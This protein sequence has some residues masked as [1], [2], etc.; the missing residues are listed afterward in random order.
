MNNNIINLKEIIQKSNNIVFFGGAGVSTESQIPDFRSARGIYAQGEGNRSRSPEEIIS[1]SFFRE[2]PTEFYDF[3]RQKLVYPEAKPNSAH[4]VLSKLEAAG[5]IKAIITQNID[6]LHQL[7]GSKNVLE[8]H[9][10]VYRNYCSGCRKLFALDYILNSKKIPLCDVCGQLIKPDVV[11]YEESLDQNIM[12]R[13]IKY[14]AQAE[15]LI[16]GGTSLTVYPAAGLIRYFTGQKLIIINKSTTTFDKSAD[17]VIN[18][19]VG[20]VFAEVYKLLSEEGDIIG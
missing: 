9:G 7:A 18:Q 20:E 16:I 1:H 12:E 15:V 11:L 4:L 5:K 3:Y 17:L 8:L 14:I 2:N 13:A 19:P 6:N 10:S